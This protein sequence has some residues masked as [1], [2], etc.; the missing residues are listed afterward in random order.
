MNGHFCKRPYASNS[1]TVTNSAFNAHLVITNLTVACEVAG[2]LFFAVGP[3]PTIR[4][5]VCEHTYRFTTFNQ[6]M[7]THTHSLMAIQKADQG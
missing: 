3:L 1:K 2:N 7:H 5:S 4:V 6:L